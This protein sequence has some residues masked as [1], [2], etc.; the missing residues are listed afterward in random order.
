M[1]RLVQLFGEAGARRV[2]ITEVPLFGRP[3]HN[4]PQIARGQQGRVQVRAL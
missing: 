4:P 2:A 1:I 3:L